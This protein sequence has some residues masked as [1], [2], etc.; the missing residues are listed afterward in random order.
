M[1]SAGAARPGGRTARNTQAVFAATIDEL[2]A[3]PYTEI[4]VE[5]I[6]A[7][8]GVHKTT[9]YRRWHSKDELVAEALTATAGTLI[10]VPDTGSAASDLRALSRSVQATLASPR[11]AAVTRSLLAGAAAGP[12]IRQLMQQFWAQRLSAIAVIVDRA[13]ARGEVPPGT[14]AARVMHAVAGPLYYKLLVTGEQLTR[15]D[16]D[17]AAA[18]ALAAAQAGVFTG[19]GG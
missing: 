7:R 18:A 16:A 17:Q 12:G 15:Q 19:S 1:S 4:S 13:T 6:A 9:V 10:E 3:R 8:A 2:S 5:T 11:G 14:G